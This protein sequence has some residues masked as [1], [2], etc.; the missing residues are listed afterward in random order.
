MEKYLREAKRAS[1]RTWAHDLYSSNLLD[2]LADPY[3]GRGKQTAEQVWVRKE[4][5]KA[6]LEEFKKRF[7]FPYADARVSIEPPNAK[8]TPRKWAISRITKHKS[9]K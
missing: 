8:D 4:E 5:R 7:G 3:I 1:I 2:Y 9:Q 6:M